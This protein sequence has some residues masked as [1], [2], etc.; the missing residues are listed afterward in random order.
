M[1]TDIASM[2][3]GGHTNVVQLIPRIQ[4]GGHQVFPWG[5]LAGVS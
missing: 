4:P 3:F 5:V 1:G 2:F